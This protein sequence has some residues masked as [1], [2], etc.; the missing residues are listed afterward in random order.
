MFIQTEETPNPLS[1]K[2]LPGRDVM[3]DR[4]PLDFASAE[5]AKPVPL[6]GKLF[7]VPGIQRVFMGRDFISITKNAQISW[8]QLKPDIFGTLMDYFTLHTS[9]EVRAPDPAPSKKSTSP[10]SP[11]EKGE[12]TEIIGEIKQLLETH[13]RPAV[14]ADGGDIIFDRFEEGI[15]YLKLRGACS[16][17]PSSTVTLKAGIENMLKHYVPEVQEVRATEEG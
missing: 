13:I 9:V 3:G 11:E 15:V 1:Q 14:A 2:F 16:G 17:C 8:S 5:D 10:Q 12:H 4:E 7:R 6:A